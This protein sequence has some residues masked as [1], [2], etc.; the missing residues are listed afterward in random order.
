MPIII[1]YA[2]TISADVI[3]NEVSKVIALPVGSRMPW[4]SGSLF[5]TL[6]F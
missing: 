3:E 2:V 6:L 5:V 1:R 4:Q